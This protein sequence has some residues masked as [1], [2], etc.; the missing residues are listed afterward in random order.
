MKY[1]LAITLLLALGCEEAPLAAQHDAT[2]D[3]SDSAVD[4]SDASDASDAIANAPDTMDAP[5]ASDAS[6][7]AQD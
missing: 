1:A 3:V 7:D 5:D 6:V 2:V 4:A